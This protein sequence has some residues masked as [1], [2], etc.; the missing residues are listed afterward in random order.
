MSGRRIILI[1]LQVGVTCLATGNEQSRIVGLVLDRND[2]RIARAVI[3]IKNAEFIRRLRSDP[4]GNFEVELPAGSYEIKV[5]Q[6]GFKTF[7]L[8]SLH[9]GAGATAR[10]NIHL[11][12]ESPRQPLKIRPA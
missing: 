10:I 3:T 12:V 1:L 11:E 9:A 4:E 7:K 6:P 2:S 5:E 8:P